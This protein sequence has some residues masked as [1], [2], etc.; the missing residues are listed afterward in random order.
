[1]SKKQTQAL[2]AQS[3]PTKGFRSHM[4]ETSG[5]QII[6]TVTGPKGWRLQQMVTPKPEGDFQTEFIRIASP[7]G[8]VEWFLDEPTRN[9]E[10]VCAA[11]AQAMHAVAAE[12]CSETNLKTLQLS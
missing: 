6:Q 1:M 2:A 4:M 5:G 7:A 10:R 9:F 11:L 12:E 3:P 8:R